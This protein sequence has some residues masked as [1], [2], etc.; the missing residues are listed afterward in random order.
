MGSRPDEGE[1]DEHPFHKVTL[2]KAFY[3]GVYEVTQSQY[4][5]V[6]H[7]NP[8][9]VKAPNHPVEYVS[10]HDAQE[11]CLRLSVKDRSANY[12]LPTEAEWEYAC[13][14][15]TQT[16]Y[17]W[18]DAFDPQYVCFEGNS[19]RSHRPVGQGKPN[20]WGF[21]DMTGNVWE[22]CQDWYDEDYYTMGKSRNPD[23]PRS[24]RA[25]VLRGGSWINGPDLFRSANRRATQP[26]YRHT[27]I[28]FRVVAQK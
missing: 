9:R 28:G 13:R 26:G 24:G 11:F 16:R 19:K 18:G 5:A 22:W 14:A 25:K 6:M 15:G 4:E 7:E 10:W 2:T 27:V 8:S 17:F 12:R 1:D 20:P 21:H 23:G 3:L